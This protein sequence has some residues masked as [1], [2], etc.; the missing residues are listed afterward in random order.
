MDR[1]FEHLG[2]A[3]T[4]DPFSTSSTNAIMTLASSLGSVFPQI[5]EVSAQ[6]GSGWSGGST[7]IPP[8][9]HQGSTREAAARTNKRKANQN[10][11]PVWMV[12]GD[13]Y[14]LAKI[15]ATRSIREHP[16]RTLVLSPKC[17]G[18]QREHPQIGSF[19]F[20]FPLRKGSE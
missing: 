15:L 3:Q 5:F 9:F 11:D 14:V 1:G 17:V 10:R 16:T 19:P 7:K 6:I 4:S 13:S 2:E 18:V 12:K 8:G 20:R